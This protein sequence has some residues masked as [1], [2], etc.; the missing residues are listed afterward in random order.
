MLRHHVLRQA[1]TQVAIQFD[2]VDQS[3]GRRCQVSHQPHIARLV[4]A[5]DDN[6]ARDAGGFVAAGFDFAEFDAVA[7]DFHLKVKAAHVL[8][9]AVVAP[10]AAVAGSVHRAFGAAKQVGDELLGSEFGP[11]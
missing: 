6:A 11:V 4:F 7:A 3:A 5:R 10:A 1:G 2:Q 9:Q 8:E